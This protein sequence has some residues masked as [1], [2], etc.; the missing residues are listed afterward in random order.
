M[1]WSLRRPAGLVLAS[2]GALG[3]WQSG[4]LTAFVAG[5]GRVFDRVLGVSTGALT[6]AAYVLD[7]MDV[8]KQAWRDISK[9]RV[10]R[11]KPRLDPPTMFGNESLY[12]ALA[13]AG[14]DEQA[15]AKTK[16]PFGIFVTEKATGRR[17]LARFSPGGTDGWDGPLTSHMVASCSIPDVFPPVPLSVG[18]K[19]TLHVDG[20]RRGDP[21]DFTY[22]AG[23][24]DVLVV[25]MIRPGEPGLWPGFNPVRWRER[26]VRRGQRTFVDRGVE[27]LAALADAPRVFRAQPS[28]VLDFSLIAFRTG[29]CRRAFELGERDAAVFSANPLQ[30][31]KPGPLPDVDPEMLL[32]TP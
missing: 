26:R 7:H 6:T 11:W 4:F 2:G 3:S 9:Q 17:R 13:H 19:T 5:H 22:L 27:S 25:E 15:K 24:K 14:D 1:N 8:L 29:V 23:M 32:S 28:E 10:L 12:E 18:G 21:P 16:V 30:A 31:H 20:A